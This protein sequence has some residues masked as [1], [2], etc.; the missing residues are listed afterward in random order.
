HRVVGVAAFASGHDAVVHAFAGDAAPCVDQHPG[1]PGA[2]VPGDVVGVGRRLEPQRALTVPVDDL[3][4]RVGDVLQ[5]LV[6]LLLHDDR[7]PEGGLPGVVV[8][9]N[10]RAGVDVVDELGGDGFD[11]APGGQFDRHGEAAVD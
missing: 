11:G 10:H 8:E 6:P 5:R 7:P 4:D 3:A 1:L 2:Q 9:Q